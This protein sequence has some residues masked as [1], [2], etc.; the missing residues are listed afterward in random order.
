MT[1]HANVHFIT[2]NDGRLAEKLAATTIT[3]SFLSPSFTL[4]PIFSAHQLASY[5]DNNNIDIVHMHWGKDLALAALAKKLSVK[6]PA[7]VYTRQMNIT[8]NKT[9]VYHRFLYREMNLMITITQRL[10]DLCIKALGQSCANKIKP[11]YY[12]VDAPSHFLSESEISE[13]RIKTG[14]K[15]D[16]FVVGCFG[17]LEDGKGQHLLIKA[18]SES[19]KQGFDLKAL[20]VGHEMNPGYRER[21]RKLTEELGISDKVVFEDFVAQPQTLMQI[22]DCVAL[23]TYEETFG[24]VLPEAMRSGV[25][26]IGSNAGGVPEIIDHEQTGLLFES[27]NAT[28]LKDQLIKLVADASLRQRLAI[29]GKKKADRL[30]NEETHFQQLTLL[31]DN[32]LT[33]HE[34]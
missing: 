23:T 27:R 18:V 19:I 30:F 22:C 25:A 10:A 13:L 11:L 24:L 15:P 17:R 12:G 26:V 20:I 33:K 6:K 14:F 4:F 2:S 34:S 7:L 1:K 31:M 3:T 28:D 8:R 32:I 5:I 16:D 29:N 21:L 9:D